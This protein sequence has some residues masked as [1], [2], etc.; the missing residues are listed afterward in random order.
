MCDISSVSGKDSDLRKELF[1]VKL[2]METM[3]Y[4]KM[5]L[6]SD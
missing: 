3:R 2:E 6:E 5:K 4:Q 1:D